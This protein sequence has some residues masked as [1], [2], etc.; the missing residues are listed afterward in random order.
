[1]QT[2]V[3][4]EHLQV[5]EQPVLAHRRDRQR[6]HVRAVVLKHPRVIPASVWSGSPRSASQ[7]VNRRSE[8]V[9]TA[10]GAGDFVTVVS[11]QRAHRFA[12]ALSQSGSMSAK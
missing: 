1:V 3:V 2:D 7:L 11:R 10:I 6:V 4:E 5:G 12:S 9:D 8:L